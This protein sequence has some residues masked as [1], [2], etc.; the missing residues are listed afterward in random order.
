MDKKNAAL[1]RSDTAGAG[2]C[3]VA[4]QARA[5]RIQVRHEASDR[6]ALTGRVAAFEHHDHALRCFLDPG[7][8]LQQL[9]RR[10]F[11]RSWQQSQ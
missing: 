3:I 7:L 1:D 4:D 8:Q 5:A 10:Y 9:C 6:I 2:L 11:C